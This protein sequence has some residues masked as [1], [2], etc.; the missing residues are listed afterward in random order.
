MFKMAGQNNLINEPVNVNDNLSLNDDIREQNNIEM[1]FVGRENDL[2]KL[3]KESEV[4]RIVGIFGIK[5]VGKSRLVEEYLK[6]FKPDGVKV[7]HIDIKLMPDIVSLYRNICTALELD[8]DQESTGSDQWIHN[9]VLFL[10]SVPGNQFLFF[11]DNTEDYQDTENLNISS[12]FLKLCT[13]MIEKCRNVQIFITSTTQVQFS[14]LGRV[15]YSHELLPLNETEARQLLENVTPKIDL[16]DYESALITL[17]E[18]LPLLI[19]M[20][21][22]ELTED[23]GMITPNNMVNLLLTGRLKALSREFYPEE[24]RVGKV[25][26][27]IRVFEMHLS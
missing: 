27:Y 26:N 2:E 6:R 1:D 23:E 15:N 14:K 12:S 5:A 10:N 11:F 7:I 17:S 24:D 13:T 3:H 8:F 22:S 9:I 20:I 16:G 25:V 4:C 18:G 19:L 21:G